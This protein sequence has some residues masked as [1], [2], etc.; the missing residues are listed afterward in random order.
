[1]SNR[2][3]IERVI[4]HKTGNLDVKR[5]A[6][7]IQEGSSG[8]MTLRWID[9]QGLYLFV[10]HGVKWYSRLFQDRPL[11]VSD[12]LNM[13]VINIDDINTTNLT[14]TNL[15]VTG[16]ITFSSGNLTLPAGSVD[17]SYLANDSLYLGST[18]LELGDPSASNTGI[19]GLATI[20]SGTNSLSIG[21]AG[22]GTVTIENHLQVDGNINVTGSGAVEV[23][24]TTQ[25]NVLID[26][27]NAEALLVRK[28]GDAGDILTVDT[29]ASK[30]T[31]GGPILAS[32]GTA[33]APAY[34][35]S[36][37]PD[38][39][40]YR[41]AAADT[42]I[43]T[44]GGT[45]IVTFSTTALNPGS[46][47][48]YYLGQNNQRW[49]GLS[50]D[51]NSATAAGL[52][53]I[54]STAQQSGSLVTITGTANKVALEVATGYLRVGGNIINDTDNSYDIGTSTRQFKDIYINGIGYIDQ[55]GTDSDPITAYINSGEIDDT[56]IGTENHS[57]GKFTTL[58][59]SGAV[60][61]GGDIDFNS[62]TINT[63]SQEVTVEVKPVI[64]SFHFD[65]AADNILS[66][67][68]SNNR[69]GIG[70][71][72]PDYMLELE[73][74]TNNSPTLCLTNSSTSDQLGSNIIFR[75]SH[76]DGVTSEG[77]SLGDMVWQAS[78][79]E[80]SNAYQNACAIK[81]IAGAEIGSSGDP[82]DSPGELQ[83]WT[84]PNG[85][86]SLA[87]RMTILE[88]GNVGIGTSSPGTA[89]EIGDGSSTSATITLNGYSSAD[90]RILF[91]N[92][93]S[94]M[95]VIGY[96]IST[97]TTDLKINCSANL[98]D[99]HL[100]VQ[101]DGNVGIGT[102]S[103]DTLLD[104]GS[105]SIGTSA[106]HIRISNTKN[107]A[108][109]HASNEEAIGGLE[110]YSA[111]TSGDGGAGVKSSVRA[112][113]DNTTYGGYY[114]LKFGVSGSTA[115]GGN[116]YTAMTI[117]ASGNVGIGVVGP[118]TKLEVL[119]GTANQLKLSFDATENCT[120]GVDTNGY[121]TITPSGNNILLADTVTNLKNTTY[122]SGLFTGDGWGIYKSGSDYNLEVDNLWVRGSMF[123]WEL[124]I[125]QI[126]ATNG[127]LVV[128]SAAKVSAVTN[129]S[130]DTW[131]LTFETG[132]T[133]DVDYH[134]FANG[135]LIMSHES[136]LGENGSPA[137]ITETQF[138]V[139]DIAV[140]DV[141]V[142][143]ATKES[144]TNDPAV[145]MTFV[146]VGN[147][148]DVARQGG[149]Y[150]TSDDSGSPFIDIWNGVT[151]FANGEAATSGDW[152]HGD[153]VK[154]RLGRLDG[155]TGG[156]NEY[157]M[158]AGKTS[159]NYIKASTSGVFIKGDEATYLKADAA[160][161]EF[162]DNNN[163][164]MDITGNSIKMYAD[165]GATVMTEWDN[166]TLVL[167]G[168]VEADP[169]NYSY[170]TVIAPTAVTVYGA[171]ATDGVFI[172]SD[173]VEIKKDTND[174]L[175]LTSGSIIMK[176]NNTP[177][178]A[179][180][181]YGMNIGPDAVAPSSADSPSAVIANVSVH[182]GGVNIYGGTDV[183]DNVAIN[184]TGMIVTVGNNAVAD[185]GS[186]VTLNGGIITLN[187]DSQTPTDNQLTITDGSIRIKEGGIGYFSIVEG[188]VT[189]GQAT[190]GHIELDSG[191]LT[192]M[193]TF[194]KVVSTFRSNELRLTPKGQ[195]S[196][197][198]GDKQVK[199]TG[200]TITFEE[201]SGLGVWNIKS[202]FGRD[203][204]LKAGIISVQTDTSGVNS[205]VKISSTGVEIIG[206]A[207]EK[208]S[209]DSGALTFYDGTNNRASIS[210][211]H[212]RLWNEAGDL[213][214][215]AN[216][217]ALKIY[218]PG[219]T[220]DYIEL[221][222]DG[223]TLV[224]DNKDN[225]IIGTESG[226]NYSSIRLGSKNLS[227]PGAADYRIKVMPDQE[228]I[229]FQRY[230]SVTPASWLPLL[231]LDYDDGLTIYDA[232]YAS[233]PDVKIASFGRGTDPIVRVGKYE[234][235]SSRL[236]IDVSGN[237]SIINRVSG[238]DTT[239]ISLNSSGSASFTG[240]VTATSGTFTG[241]INASG[242]SFTGSVNVASN[243]VI[244]TWGGTILFGSGSTRENILIGPSTSKPGD[245]LTD[246]TDTNDNIAIGANTLYKTED[247]SYNIAIGQSAMRFINKDNTDTYLHCLTNT[248]VG[249]FAM[250][251]WGQAGYN[252]SA[253]DNVAIGYNAAVNFGQ[254]NSSSL[255][256]G[257]VCI[258]A[259]AGAV[260][261]GDKNIA[262]GFEAG[263]GLQ[264][265]TDNI[266]IGNGAEPG[267]SAYVNTIV[268]GKDATGM[269]SN[270][271]KIGSSSITHTRLQGDVSIGTDSVG[272]INQG[273]WATTL[274]IESDADS[275]GNED[276]PIIEL[277]YHGES[278]TGENIGCIA[279]LAN[280]NPLV[281][282]IG[283][284]QNT[285]ENTGDLRFL[286]MHNST[287][288]ERFRITSDGNVE[289]TH[290]D[291]HTASDIRLK[292]N[293]ETIPNALERVKSLRGVNFTWKDK[294]KEKLRI[295][296]IA[297]EVEE[298]FPES[299]HTEDTEEAIKSVEYQFLVGAL[300]EAV[301]ELSAKV[302][303]L[304]AQ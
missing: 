148:S 8:A 222:G 61:I 117:K 248:A 46:D 36:G 16:G 168:D 181:E 283:E 58:E 204:T 172:T 178:L 298:V 64:G 183:D 208:L 150:L 201:F 137:V 198:A 289:G 270:T 187:G 209:V 235:D 267:G 97:S 261:S 302:E 254:H 82:S 132:D 122:T 54:N 273:N 210:S 185:F 177:Q 81:G 239:A 86:E 39:G 94:T 78:N 43:A 121:L 134:P 4:E 288:E 287:V 182:S 59:A 199:V 217:S 28:N 21:K 212:L 98:S 32:N 13:A 147:T 233:N 126:R 154:V 102:T 65:G 88:S 104:I 133:S 74:S 115:S 49:K 188:T 138:Q 269:G 100:V 276:P 62:A 260:V 291:Y 266:I 108:D 237:L 31:M 91:E 125:N 219:S 256:N 294:D 135:D 55:L 232:N 225:I 207:S 192:V 171:N 152:E 105:A 268:I 149:V 156:T 165:D 191:G 258:G 157:G 114:G 170:S 1:M 205:E 251:G 253:R 70:T 76:T 300:V 24:V 45:A 203:I 120:F 123:V 194:D 146:R 75:N 40:F 167:G 34:S 26:S 10:K 226:D 15:T 263:M 72:T 107:A 103:P 56:P 19:D 67:D 200:S 161:I 166:T 20:N 7:S 275:P 190:R 179:V 236:E 255:I 89:L 174:S 293:I 227:S 66:I 221:D 25:G 215:E 9:G 280:G 92:N 119:A 301:K 42:F 193:D 290:G 53:I 27:T 139:T 252:N 282:I 113:N 33:G 230:S 116:D 110:F 281:Q 265:N 228:G 93:T 218:G 30:V 57:T 112:Y 47:G 79:N 90:S 155:Q 68:G 186:N 303:A 216:S 304:E 159:T 69:V 295:G 271:V 95:G 158:W 240:A 80:D 153:K 131:N 243:I 73:S 173:G 176:S 23:N 3:R 35:F 84:T 206:P 262:I 292:D 163:K 127:S 124:V 141:N 249:A 202:S 234:N 244:N 299:V 247:G 214:L 162:Y 143:E 2:S 213:G 144:T 160:K 85:S 22:E 130:G 264:T 277:S 101:S 145:G 38:T 211:T 52:D 284:T 224:N 223:I 29:Y 60:T 11:T 83:F 99:N 279:M 18:E 6:P 128:T 257:N 245:A 50:I 111:D 164:K 231:S 297:Q 238:T 175:S 196:P 241:T 51:A 250:Q 259:N 180:S 197:S 140:G 48:A 296:L 14:L 184:D 220:N 189:V 17:N 246:T 195:T 129:V 278:L 151:D 136:T 118:N 272:R 106:P 87:Q 285:S 142:L 41:T 37:D 96:D 229:K 274:T 109:W 77:Q 63:A 5:G 71:A 169:A 12:E 242:G 44:A 286:L